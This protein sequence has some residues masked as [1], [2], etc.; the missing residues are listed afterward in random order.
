MWLIKAGTTILINAPFGKVG[1]SSSSQSSDGKWVYIDTAPWKGYTTSEDRIYEKEEV[2]DIV[3]VMN[4][5]GDTVP[6]WIRHNLE[7][8]KGAEVIVTCKGKWA[9]VKRSDIQYLD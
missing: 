9:R 1:A 5:A 2:Y 4:D 3:R 7:L 8:A 6:N